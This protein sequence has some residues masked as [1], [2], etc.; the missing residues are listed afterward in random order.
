M[1]LSIWSLLG[2]VLTLIQL[3][4][5]VRVLVSWV[6]PWGRSVWGKLVTLITEPILLPLRG[7]AR[8]SGP[9]IGVD[10]SPMIALLIIHIVRL[11]L[12]V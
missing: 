3:L 7:I 4:L 11:V 9:G 2:S 5:L 1:F 8:V 12:R 10:F 6:P